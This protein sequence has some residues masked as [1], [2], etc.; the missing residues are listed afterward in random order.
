MYARV[1]TVSIQP[2][3]LDE[4]IN[5]FRDSIKPASKQQKGN[6]G[7]YLL[8]DRKTGKAI[9]IAFWET[10]ADMAAGETSDYLREQIAKVASAFTAAP[11][12]EH[13][14]VSVE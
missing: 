1:V 13:Y 6:R 11:I 9:S 12:T 5:V 4:M 2:D 10:E 3:R 14:E 7:G 8:T